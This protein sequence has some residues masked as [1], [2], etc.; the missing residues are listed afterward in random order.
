M[1]KSIGR[2]NHLFIEPPEN[3]HM[4]AYQKICVYE[5]VHQLESFSPSV[6]FVQGDANLRAT[7]PPMYELFM[8][9]LMQQNLEIG[10]Y[11]ALP[12]M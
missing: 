1:L 11:P 3:S 4:D 10:S 9:L 8:G 2:I 12:K 7:P 6:S 5:N